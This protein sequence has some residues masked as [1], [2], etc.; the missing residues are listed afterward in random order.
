MPLACKSRHVV[1]AGAGIGGLT[2][3]IA[4]A[5]DGHSV[6]LLE[7]APALGAIG[8]G[9]TL[10][11]NAM[12]VFSHLGLQEAICATGVEPKRQRAQHWS[13]GRVLLALERGN[14]MRDLYGA[15]YIY[16]HRV[17][18][19]RVLIEAIQATGR[20][21]LHLGAIACGS[22]LTPSGAAIILADGTTMAGDIV[23]GADGLKSA[24][25][26]AFDETTPHFTGHIAWRAVIPVQGAILEDL[27]SYPGMHLGP[28]KMVVR[29]PV[30]A[31]QMLNMVF[32][33]R[34]TGWAEEGWA[35]PGKV[36]ELR[37]LF[38][39]WA[40][41]IGHII[42]AIDETTL[43]KWAIF[44]RRPLASFVRDGR[45]ALLGDAAH[46]MTPFLGQGASTAVEDAL[47]LARCLHAEPENAAALARYDAARRERCSFIQ[48]ESNANADRLQ[49]EESD[50][51]G[52]KNLRNEETLGLFSYDASSVEV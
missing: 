31:G 28:G 44:A 32:F 24:I 21:K 41:Q 35:I 15:P 13:D 8:A 42:D 29:Y 51:F 40:P 4:L 22:T 2:A 9:V 3:A 25:R 6:D 47:I 23:I 5:V 52:M 20:V 19:H 30:R 26:S 14:T 11:P 34:E 16:I 18:L 17:D 38:G 7:Q 49:G 43:N 39:E 46:A 27:A 37:A 12:R 48:T 50:V 36:A 33:A 10:A 45:I 1:I